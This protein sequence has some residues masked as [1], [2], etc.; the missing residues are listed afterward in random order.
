MKIDVMNPVSEFMAGKDVFPMENFLNPQKVIDS[1]MNCEYVRQYHPNLSNE[2]QLALDSP[3]SVEAIYA[4]SRVES[5]LLAKS[6]TGSH[7]ERGDGKYSHMI[8]RPITKQ[9]HSHPHTKPPHQQPASIPVL[10][11][12]NGP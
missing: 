10:S 7:S 6:Q 9:L 1:L 11:K 3:T 2:V 5:E 8:F 12:E 4:E